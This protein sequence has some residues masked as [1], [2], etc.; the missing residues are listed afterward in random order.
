[1][2]ESVRDWGRDCWCDT[3]C[4]NTCGKRF[5]QQHGT[6]PPGYDHKYVYSELG[7]NLKATDLQAAVGA[8]Q[9]RRL[10]EFVQRRAHNHA[11]LRDGLSDLQDVLILPEASPKASP[12]WF[13]FTICL[14]EDAPISRNDLR[15]TLE[16]RGIA[17]RQLFAGNLLRQPAYQN[18]EHRVA[19]PLTVTNQITE[20]AFWIGCYPGLTDPHIDHTID[21]VREALSPRVQS[22]PAAADLASS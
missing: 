9:L 3:G 1:M 22:A 15:H 5:N 12:S 8:V 13:G 19:G 10:D 21:Q 11:R 4:D 20:H 6:L 17:T 7:Y 14:R 16:A 18:V 2:A